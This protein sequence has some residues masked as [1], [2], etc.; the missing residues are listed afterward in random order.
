MKYTNRRIKKR[1]IFSIKEPSKQAV[2]LDANDFKKKIYVNGEWVE[3]GGEP[4]QSQINQYINEYFQNTVVDQVITLLP[5]SWT[6]VAPVIGTTQDTIDTQITNPVEGMFV[7]TPSANT[8]YEGGAW[9][10]SIT[11]I[12]AGTAYMIL[13]PSEEELQLVLHGHLY[14]PLLRRD[15][16]GNIKDWD[17][18]VD[19]AG[20][21]AY[22][23]T[24][25]MDISEAVFNID[26][27]DGM[28]LY[29]HDDTRPSDETA[30]LKVCVF[31]DG[32][33]ADEYTLT[34]GTAYKVSVQENHDHE[35]A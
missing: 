23:K 31:A 1:Q 28:A 8:I 32:H 19:E 15:R 27:V 3:I 26:L 18:Q 16:D 9:T 10:G 5:N 7:K 13:N 35:R 25:P 24:Y 4:S 20:W 6:W 22:L 34:P 2:W 14:N 12:E 29:V 21:A 17:M 11:Q 33:W 30:E